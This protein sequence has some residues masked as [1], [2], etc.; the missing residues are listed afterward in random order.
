MHILILKYSSLN[1]NPYKETLDKFSHASA[2]M[3]DRTP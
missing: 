3:T 1:Y 2:L